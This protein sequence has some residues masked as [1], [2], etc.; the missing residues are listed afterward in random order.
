METM[1]YR[2]RSTTVKILAV[3][4]FAM[5]LKVLMAENNVPAIH[6]TSIF[7]DED[8]LVNISVFLN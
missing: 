7:Q 6:A 8:W 5:T 4:R 3:L 1:L 2:K